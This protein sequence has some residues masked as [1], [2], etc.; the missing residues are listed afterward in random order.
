MTMWKVMKKNMNFFAFYF[1]I[2]ASLIVV[3]R[4]ITGSE[5]STVFVI[6]AG[7][8][9]FVLVFGSTFTN[10]Q[11]EEKNKG[12]KFLDTLPVTAR[13]IAEAK[14][15][16]VLMAVGLCVGFLVI[17]ISSSGS[18]PETIV[19]ARS[20]VLSMGVISLILTGVN[21]IGIFALGFTKYLVIVGVGWLTLS[22]VPMI[23]LRTY[24][25]RTDILRE[26]V[27]NFFAGIDWLIVIPS[28]LVIYFVLMLVAAKVRHLR[29]T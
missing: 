28:V 15:A 14:Y 9:V 17:L 29:S 20:Y 18:D 27:L 23:V 19:I 5:L 7:I 16:L 22:L 21:Y 24:E 10:E 13:E 4:F 25:G 1:I 11:Y 12:Y 2:I 3:L 6:I 8:L 26:N